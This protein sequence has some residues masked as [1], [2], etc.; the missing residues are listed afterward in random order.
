VSL[1]VALPTS[2]GVLIASDSRSL[3]GEEADG[4]RIDTSPKVTA[5]GSF[6]LGITGL[7]DDA[8]HLA[9][10]PRTWVL[11]YWRQHHY[12]V[13]ADTFDAFA[14]GLTA[15][16]RS[17]GLHPIGDRWRSNDCVCVL[18]VSAPSPG[19]SLLGFVGVDLDPAG[20]ASVTR[21]DVAGLPGPVKLRFTA[22]PDVG[23]EIVR[24]CRHEH[25][26]H[27]RSTG[28]GR[29][30]PDQPGLRRAGKGSRVQSETD[31]R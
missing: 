24:A 19:I 29:A 20:E 2:A 9:Y 7:L 28:Q 1:L 30:R 23:A 16:V 21:L 10:Q 12:H 4:E 6:A 17:S 26:G 13:A 25:I 14:A 31:R 11:D 27:V 8:E 3:I 15:Y 22:L 18:I 5:Y